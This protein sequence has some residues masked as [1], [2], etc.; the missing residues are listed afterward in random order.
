M[1]LEPYI[2]GSS[3]RSA[4]SPLNGG[5]NG[6]A[7]GL[8]PLLFDDSTATSV[9]ANG[10]KLED[11]ALFEDSP[12]AQAQLREILWQLSNVAAAQQ[13]V[14]DTNNSHGALTPTAT[15][16]VVTTS[17]TTAVTNSDEHTTSSGVSGRHSGPPSLGHLNGAIN[18]INGDVDMPSKRHSLNC[19]T[20]SLFRT[21]SR[22]QT[23]TTT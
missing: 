1:Q 11:A 3:E 4:D 15:A 17:S 8:D 6:G 7:L 22:H 13:R 9:V 2:V 16:T 12:N 10:S 5:V 20:K 19:H 21:Q 23:P 18:G 14:N